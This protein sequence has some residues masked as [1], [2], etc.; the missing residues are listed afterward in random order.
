VPRITEYPNGSKAEFIL[1]DDGIGIK[2]TL[3]DD[4]DTVLHI[5]EGGVTVNG[6]P[7]VLD[8]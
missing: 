3:P 4:S 8:E 1:G 2:F 5:G 7:V 6:I